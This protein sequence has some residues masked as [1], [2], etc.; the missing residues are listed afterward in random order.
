MEKLAVS[1]HGLMIVRSSMPDCPVYVTVIDNNNAAR[2]VKLRVGQ[3]WTHQPFRELIFDWASVK[4]G[5]SHLKDQPELELWT[6]GRYTD[7]KPDLFQPIATP[8]PWQ[9]RQRG[10]NAGTHYRFRDYNS[11]GPVA[12]TPV[13]TVPQGKYAVIED[14]QCWRQSG[15]GGATLGSFMR[16]KHFPPSGTSPVTVW[17]WSHNAASIDSRVWE[18]V[19]RMMHEYQTLY[20]ELTTSTG[21]FYAVTLTEY[22]IDE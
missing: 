3:G 2:P 19:G 21:G 1:G 16:I 17:E 6:W 4:N 22:P 15:N 18:A 10:F 7:A 8:A 14:M 20:W 9:D 5:S 12:E 13:Y 11:G